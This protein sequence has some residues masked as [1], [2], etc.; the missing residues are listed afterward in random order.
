MLR[1]SSMFVGGDADA[2]GESVEAVTASAAASA[3]GF[4]P[5][6]EAFEDEC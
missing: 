2:A 4:G 6:L 3:A 1:R 5:E